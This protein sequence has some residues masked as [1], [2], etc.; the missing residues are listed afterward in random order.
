M[1]RLSA[2]T[3]VT[4]FTMSKNIRV[5]YFDTAMVLIEAD[6]IRFLTDP[7]LD[8]VGTTFDH[9]PTHLE[10]TGA[11]ATHLDLLKPVHVVLLSHDQHGDNLDNA[12]RALLSRVPRILTTP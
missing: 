12:G 5:T 7:V 11:A 10:K 9:G 6:G 3:V 2:R 4:Q 1:M 8:P